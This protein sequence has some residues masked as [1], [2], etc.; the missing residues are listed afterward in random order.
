[1][2]AKLAFNDVDLQPERLTD[3]LG[4]VDVHA[5]DRLVVGVEELVGRVGGS[6]ATVIVPLLLMAAGT[7]IDESAEALGALLGCV[8]DPLLLLPQAARARARLAA[9][10]TAALRLTRWVR[11]AT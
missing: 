9:V 3:R 10:P 2:P 1:M 7:E 5:D 8:L 4:E 11:D 6:V